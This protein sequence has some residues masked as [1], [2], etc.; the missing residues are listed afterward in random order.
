[1]L[2]SP[3]RVAPVAS[4]FQLQSPCLVLERSI[5]RGP[6]TFCVK[7]VGRA[8]VFQSCTALSLINGKKLV[9]TALA[10]IATAKL[11]VELVQSGAGQL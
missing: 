2:S 5:G 10:L 3:F 11:A 9:C 8:S 1:M 7:V 4:S 6:L